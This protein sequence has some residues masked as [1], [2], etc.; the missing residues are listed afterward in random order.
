MTVKLELVHVACP[1]REGEL[2]P[3][4]NVGLQITE[5]SGVYICPCCLEEVLV[6]VVTGEEKKGYGTPIT[7]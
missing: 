7:P 4:M 6:R 1:K 2:T 5:R 3:P